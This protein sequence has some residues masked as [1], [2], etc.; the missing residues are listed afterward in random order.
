MLHATQRWVRLY[1]A[2]SP[3]PGG[4]TL[5]PTVT[6]FCIVWSQPNYS[7][8]LCFSAGYGTVP[9][10]PFLSGLDDHCPRVTRRWQSKWYLPHGACKR[11]HQSL[12]G[13]EY[14]VP[15]CQH[16]GSSRRRSTCVCPA[17]ISP[18]YAA[19]DRKPSCAYESPGEAFGSF[20]PVS[21]LAESGSSPDAGVADVQC[22]LSVRKHHGN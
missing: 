19:L 3:V 8:E 9:R 4:R 10:R 2:L 21:S 16:S 17:D 13:A 14:K 5:V 18:K 1:R 11:L 6:E 15:A 7:A 22:Q 20:P 12:R